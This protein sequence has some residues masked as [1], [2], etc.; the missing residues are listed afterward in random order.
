MTDQELNNLAEKFAN[1]SHEDFD[2]NIDLHYKNGF[3][4]GYA[5]KADQ[6]IRVE[7][8]LPEERQGWSN[9]EDVNIFREGGI[10][11]T[12][13]YRYSCGKIG[14]VDYLYTNREEPVIAWQP[15]PSPPKMDKI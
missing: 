6:W 9:S 15:L 13:S 8:R 11:S 14:W 7:D 5:Y 2:G 4:Q 1:L 3:L 12:G 10:V